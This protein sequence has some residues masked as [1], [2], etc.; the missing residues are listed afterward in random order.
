MYIDKQISICWDFSKYSDLIELPN[1]PVTETQSTE[2]Y[3]NSN[4]HQKNYGVGEDEEMSESQ[5][6]Q[7]IKIAFPANGKD[8]HG[9][10]L[11]I[12]VYHISSCFIINVYSCFKHAFTS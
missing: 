6:V 2:L 7:Y 8:Q 1:L 4:E 10:L 3:H 9:E 11:I 5:E 12:K